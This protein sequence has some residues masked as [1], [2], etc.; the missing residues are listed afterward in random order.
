VVNQLA[1]AFGPERM[2][3]G[4]GFTGAET[5]GESYRAAFDYG[6]RLLSEKFSATE[7]AQV[8]GGNAQRLFGFEA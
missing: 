4:G 7:Q 2:I 3:Y 8:L 1:E 5:T 6:A